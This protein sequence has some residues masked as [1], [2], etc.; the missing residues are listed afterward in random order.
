MLLSFAKMGKLLL[1]LI[2]IIALVQL[3]STMPLFDENGVQEDRG[4]QTC[5]QDC[6]FNRDECLKCPELES[7]FTFA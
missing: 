3:S 2:L 7:E 6:Q 1:P 5:H 4:Y